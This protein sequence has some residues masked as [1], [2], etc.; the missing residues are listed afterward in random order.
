MHNLINIFFDHF[1][2][3]LLRAQGLKREIDTLGLVYEV[4]FIAAQSNGN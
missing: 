3:N 4:T 2:L 1:F